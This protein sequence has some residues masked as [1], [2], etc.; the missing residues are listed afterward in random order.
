MISCD[1]NYEIIY[2]QYFVDKKNI[3]F[4][5]SIS[6]LYTN[7]KYITHLTTQQIRDTTLI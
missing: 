1:K 2:C 7:I 4:C 3:P 6:F 5:I